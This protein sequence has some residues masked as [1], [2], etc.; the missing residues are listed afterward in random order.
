MWGVPEPKKN[1]HIVKQRAVA[2][3]LM[4][5]WI[6][7]EYGQHET[8]DEAMIER[9]ARAL[10]ESDA[11]RFAEFVDMTV[12]DKSK[13]AALYSDGWLVGLDPAFAFFACDAARMLLDMVASALGAITRDPGAGKEIFGVM[14]HLA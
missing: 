5:E 2:A 14:T 1:R 11:G 10:S 7:K 9:G 13:Q 3:L 12:I 8:L 6:D 4:A